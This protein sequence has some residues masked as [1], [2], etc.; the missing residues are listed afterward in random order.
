MSHNQTETAK[1]IDAV[2]ARSNESEIGKISKIIGTADSLNDEDKKKVF[3]EV[4]GSIYGN[5]LLTA[6][7]NG[8]RRQIY[9]QIEE[10]INR[11]GNKRSSHIPCTY[12][13]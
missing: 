3:D 10:K 12:N 7:R 2:T 1:T 8:A 4:A 5:A 6:A 13:I 9:N 11:D